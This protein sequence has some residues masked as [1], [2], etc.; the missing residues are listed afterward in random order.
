[1]S[2]LLF[3]HL[4]LQR[5]TLFGQD[6]GGLIGLRL[7]AQQPQRF[8]RVVVS[9]TGLPTGE[10]PPSDAFMKWRNYSQNAK[11][12]PVGRI[13]SGGCA[14][15]LSDAAIAAYD[16]PFPDDRRPSPPHPAPAHA[17]QC[18]VH[19]PHCRSFT[20]AATRQLLQ[21]HSCSNRIACSHAAA[22]TKPPPASSP[23]SSPCRP[24]TPPPPTT[25]Q[26]GCSCGS[27]TCPRSAASAT[28]TPS[29]AE[30][31]SRL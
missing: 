29:P 16:A 3:S 21:P 9:N 27:C 31:Q 14:S 18:T 30:A 5:I 17:Q 4:Q 24:P 23:L 1:M 19:L 26:L 2:Q 12:F 6:W 11:D 20:A 8:A 15:Q 22:A 10:H 13:I 25:L 7:L 28:A